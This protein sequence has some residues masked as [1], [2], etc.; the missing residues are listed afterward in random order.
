MANIMSNFKLKNKPSRS[1]FDL[2][3]RTTFSAK[4]GELLPC[5]CKEVLPGDK[6]KIKL[7]SFTRLQPL[8]A[9]AFVRLREYYD[10]VYVP[11]RLLWRYADALFDQMPNY[12]S[13]N[14]N[15]SD[16]LTVDKAP[17]FTRLTCN[18][19][20]DRLTN[21][22]DEIGFNSSYGA[23]KLLDLLGYGQVW[24]SGN[25]D[26]SGNHYKNTAFNIFP[27][28]AYQKAYCDIFRFDQWEQP[29]P[30]TYNI[31]YADPGQALDLSGLP[32]LNNFFTLRYANYPKDL[33]M[34]LLPNTQ[35]GDVSVVT[36]TSGIDLFQ[37]RMGPSNYNQVLRVNGSTGSS[38]GATGV[39]L[40]S[41]AS[42]NNYF[43]FSILALRQAE[44]LQKYKEISLTS[45][46]DHAAQL[47]AHW[48]VNLSKG[49][50]MMSE[51][52]GGI[53][54]NVQI[55][56][57]V[58]QNLSSSNDTSE[59]RG[60]GMSG[61]NG[62]IDYS[63]PEHGYILCIY[64]CAPIIDYDGA[65]LIFPQNLHLDSTDFAIPELDRAGMQS[66]PSEWYF[67]SQDVINYTISGDA[68]P[69][70]ITDVPSV[71]GYAPRY[72]E[73]KTDVDTCHGLFSPSYNTEF[74]SWVSPFWL[75]S[76]FAGSVH[77]R[78]TSSSFK[79]KSYQ[80]DNL[81]KVKSSPV[82]TSDQLLVCSDFDVKAV[83]NLDYDGMPY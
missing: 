29:S 47:K 63:V 35:Y 10:F 33:L 34:G 17:Y 43:N 74:S 32:Y 36:T 58:N 49:R 31:D 1:G 50:S 78:I 12:L 82:V 8:A 39:P 51:Y 6:F 25:S 66:A 77:T 41:K 23:K 24:F 68:D 80:F 16:V 48:N 60:I 13:S 7:N 37:T 79:I 26:L 81:F 72:I 75:K 61:T 40:D 19:V 65:N 28:L 9:P 11:T 18:D 69:D 20:L 52:L 3:K 64:H 38:S 67:G 15:I 56:S 62:T 53:S 57:V 14:S 59:L 54:Q 55:D 70:N 83:R 22:E 71:V 76:L 2:T 27:L 5:Y 44:L 73:Y 45:K 30:H 42:I 21:Y 4:I 46:Q